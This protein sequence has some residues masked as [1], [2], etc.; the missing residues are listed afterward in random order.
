MAGISKDAKGWRVRF[1][2]GDG[3]TRTIRLSGVNKSTAITFKTHVEHLNAARC[4]NSTPPPSTSSW[5]GDLST[6]LRH[7]LAAAGLVDLPEEPDPVPVED[8]DNAG[9]CL[10]DFLAEHREHGMTKRGRSA[11]KLTVEKWRAPMDR[12]IR[13]FGYD[14]DITTI[15]RDDAYQYRV[16]L[17][18]QRICR[19]KANPGGRALSSNTIHKQVDNAK[20]FF[21]AAESRGL[22]DSNPFRL[23]VSATEPNRERDFFLPRDLT[24]RIIAECPDAE[25]R[26]LVALWRYAGLEDGSVRAE[27]GGRVVAIRTA[28]CSCH[29]DKALPQQRYPLRTDTGRA[30]IPGRCVSGFTGA[31]ADHASGRCTDHHTIQR[32]QQQPRQAVQV[33]SAPGWNRAVAEVV[34]EHACQLRNGDAADE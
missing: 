26:L 27:V 13:F 9:V 4:A 12:L 19:T 29:K 22:I 11:A 24:E 6:K 3:N 25:W 20:V 34:P 16:W 17:G 5:V 18:K 2:D 7:K 1:Q 31:R 8:T 28:A 10:G 30:D 15:T 21:N 33:D 32:H 23:I 14:R